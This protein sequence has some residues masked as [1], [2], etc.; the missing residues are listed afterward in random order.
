MKIKK[1][2]RS[3]GVSFDS[4]YM[5]ESHGS[6]GN[7][8]KDN[9]SYYKSYAQDGSINRANSRTILGVNNI[10]IDVREGSNNTSSGLANYSSSYNTRN[11]EYTIDTS[12]SIK[13]PTTTHVDYTYSDSNLGSYRDNQ[14]QNNQPSYTAHLTNQEI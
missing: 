4:T 9:Y 14:W 3:Y 1:I 11:F 2:S 5:V 13:N 8:S 7:R 12:S 10:S 6:A